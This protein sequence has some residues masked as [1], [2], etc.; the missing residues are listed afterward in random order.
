MC[1]LTIE[2]VLF[3]GCKLPNVHAGLGT[4][5][6]SSPAPWPAGFSYDRMCSLTKPGEGAAE[7]LT[8]AP[9]TLVAA[10]PPA[11]VPAA[12]THA[13]DTPASRVREQARA[14]AQAG[15]T[16]GACVLVVHG[17]NACSAA[18]YCCRMYCCMPALPR[19]I[20]AENWQTKAGKQ[21]SKR[22]WQHAASDCAAKT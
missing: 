11:G 7:S 18:M 13:L 3:R 14:R 2:C 16:G 21:A 17:C 12:C 1:S 22:A 4:Q 15:A 5:L 19:C 9:S 20:A 8:P 10:A 6:A